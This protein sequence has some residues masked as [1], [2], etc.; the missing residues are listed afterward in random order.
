MENLQNS[1]LP[2]ECICLVNLSLLCFLENVKLEEESP[3]IKETT[4]L[5]SVQQL[6]NHFRVALITVVHFACYQLVLHDQRNRNQ[7]INQSINQPDSDEIGQPRGGPNL[8]L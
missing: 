5:G 1:I 4:F 7:S 3:L 8:L 2:A 6:R